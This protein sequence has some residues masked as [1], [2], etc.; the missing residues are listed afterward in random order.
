MGAIQPLP[1]S[2]QEAMSEFVHGVFDRK[3]DEMRALIWTH[4]KRG[5]LEEKITRTF[6]NL[7]EMVQYGM[8]R[9]GRANVYYG[10]GVAPYDCRPNERFIAKKIKGLVALNADL[11]VQDEVHKKKGLPETIED[12][13]GVIDEIA[14]R[15][16]F[17][18]SSG[19]GIQA[20][21]VF[22]EPLMF[23]N[24]DEWREGA[25]LAMWWNAYVR[26]RM[27]LHG[28]TVDSTF[29]LARVLR[30][31]GTE[32]LKN[33]D[34]IRPVELLRHNPE[35]YYAREDFVLHLGDHKDITTVPSTQVQAALDMRAMNKTIVANP[36]AAPNAKKLHE[37]EGRNPK[38]TNT[39]YHKRQDDLASASEYDFSIALAAVRDGT[40]ADQE[41]ADLLIMH[42][43]DVCGENAADSGAKMRRVDYLARTIARARATVA[44][45]EQQRG[46]VDPLITGIEERQKASAQV[47][48]QP[49]S[50]ETGDEEELSDEDIA[51][52]QEVEQELTLDDF[53]REEQLVVPLNPKPKKAGADASAGNAKPAK[54]EAKREVFAKNVLAESANKT[55]PE[56]RANLLNGLNTLYPQVRFERIVCMKGDPTMYR[57]EMLADGEYHK[58]TLSSIDML[59]TQRNFRAQIAAATKVLLTEAKKIDWENRVRIMLAASEDEVLGEEATQRGT[60]NTWLR[61][62]L[63][64]AVIQE[65]WNGNMDTETLRHAVVFDGTLWIIGAP[66]HRWLRS[67]MGE[68]I[69]T[70]A[71][72]A[73][74]R[75]RGMDWRAIP[76]KVNKRA[77]TRSAWA[78][79][80]DIAVEYLTNP[81]DKE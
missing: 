12:A 65:D 38:F 22:G 56:A 15:P 33:P 11:D 43:R 53:E 76:C 21:W 5:P 72:G 59:M 30:L 48:A 73:A 32:N 7:D 34:D 71:L 13:L 81:D 31:P 50:D 60:V 80:D 64:G 57:I 55:T 2:P 25:D 51:A 74:F 78:V 49:Q 66:F 3:P 10:L 54:K 47:I 1:Y 23:D 26:G 20:L 17:V 28:W 45:E 61:T 40:W 4:L 35:A 52:M 79:P 27:A 16:T 6:T 8:E 69:S 39:L 75:N 14:L 77:T 44:E 58:I 36:M 63:E 46:V 24:D 19:H 42:R 70:V 37:L 29:D 18:V 62:Y 67:D 41:I 9:S 68:K